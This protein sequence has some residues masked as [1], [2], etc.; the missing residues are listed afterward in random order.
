MRIQTAQK[1]R[2][3]ND[4]MPFQ[5]KSSE[6]MLFL[7]QFETILAQRMALLTQLCFYLSQAKLL[8]KSVSLYNALWNTHL[9]EI[10]PSSKLMTQTSVLVRLTTHCR[11]RYSLCCMVE[12]FL[13]FLMQQQQSSNATKNWTH[14][15]THFHCNNVWSVLLKLSSIK[16]FMVWG[17][18]RNDYYIYTRESVK[19]RANINK[20]KMG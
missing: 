3:V 12:T 6:L 5:S 1:R 16:W 20:W 11:R 14:T 18:D 9:F 10:K 15:R 7:S 13:E 17:D 8:F 19:K 2:Y 4:S